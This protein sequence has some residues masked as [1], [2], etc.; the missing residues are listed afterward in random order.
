[1][2]EDD[3][4]ELDE[5]DGVVDGEV[6]AEYGDA[7]SVSA[8]RVPD[9]EGMAVV[10]DEAASD[11]ARRGFLA[12]LLVGGVAAAALGGSAAFY[13]DQRRREAEPEFVVLPNGADVTVEGQAQLLDRIGEI[14]AALA[15]MTADRDRLAEELARTNDDLTLVRGDLDDAQVE[16]EEQRR[17]NTLWEQLDAIGLDDLLDTALLLAGSALV[18]VLQVI[19]LLRTGI[20]AAQAVLNGFVAVFPGPQAGIRWL[21]RQVLA[22]A[23]NLEWLGQQIEQAIEPSDSLTA[24]VAE[25]VLWVLDRLPFGVGSRAQAGLEAMQT[26]VND[27]PDLLAGLNDDVLDPLADWFGADEERNLLGALVDP[28]VENAIEPGESVLEAVGEFETVYKENLVDPV[29]G[30]LAQRAALR[31]EI[32]SVRAGLAAHA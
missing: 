31:D 26:I 24:M 7:T 30:A 29:Q 16:L 6:I 19:V 28:V 21:G 1:M 22:L 32:E 14:E 18:R 9:E 11:P 23:S 3:R 5:M 10:P 2:D 27:L 8:P 15:A 4:T 12:R 17:L 25:F 20:A 13:Y